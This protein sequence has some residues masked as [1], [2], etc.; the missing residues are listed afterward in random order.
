ML[1]RIANY[2]KAHEQARG[3]KSSTQLRQLAIAVMTYAAEHDDALPPS[4]EALQPYIDPGLLHSPWG[5]ASDGRGDYWMSTTVRRLSAC[6]FPERK[7]AFYDRA[8]YEHTDE[9]AVGFYDGHVV[10]M[11]TWELDELMAD[12]PNAGTDF[13]LPEGW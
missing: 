13:D 2:A 6:R 9:V 3:L 4:V 11:S 7:I 8:M 10:I 1:V 5:P 12:E